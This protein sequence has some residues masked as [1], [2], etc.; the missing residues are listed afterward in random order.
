MENI[1]HPL[2]FICK[3]EIKDDLCDTDKVIYIGKDV[4][5]DKKV[6]RHIKCMYINIKKSRKTWL[7][8]PKTKVKSSDKIYD[9][10][11]EKEKFRKDIN[12]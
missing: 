10:N 9:R 1:I 5:K 6:Y 3:K 12:E 8:N 7:I 11:K 4:I 2:C